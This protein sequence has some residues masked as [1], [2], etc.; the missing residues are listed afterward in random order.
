[1]VGLLVGVL[2]KFWISGC[3]LCEVFLNFDYGDH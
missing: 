2:D 3:F 1:M